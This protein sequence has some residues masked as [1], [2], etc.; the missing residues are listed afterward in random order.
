[1]WVGHLLLPS[2]RVPVGVVDLVLRLV[3]LD[4]ARRHQKLLRRGAP[5]PQELEVLVDH[6]E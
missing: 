3:V 1:M 6:L 4:G 5:D 2:P